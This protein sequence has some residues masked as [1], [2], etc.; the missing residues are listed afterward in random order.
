MKN[1]A[2]VH[3]KKIEELCKEFPNHRQLN[4]NST[5]QHIEEA[6]QKASQLC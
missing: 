6:S 2:A 4:Q 5:R 1:E 3:Q